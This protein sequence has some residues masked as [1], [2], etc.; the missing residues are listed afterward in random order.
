MIVE[1]AKLEAE[2]TVSVAYNDVFLTVDDLSTARTRLS[3]VVDTLAAI[4]ASVVGFD[5]SDDEILDTLFASLPRL[6][7]LISTDYSTKGAAE[8]KQ[9][10]PTFAALEDESQEFLVVALFLLENLPEE[11]DQS[12]VSISAW[13]AVE[14]ELN[15]KILLPFRDAFV[16]EHSEV[17]THL[18]SDLRARHGWE[19]K[20]LAKY[21]RDAKPPALGQ[22]LG[23]IAKCAHSKKTV[24]ESTALGA[25][26][27]YYVQTSDTEPFLF[28]KA[29]VLAILS[30][31]VI[32]KFRNGAAHTSV[33]NHQRARESFDYVLNALSKI[34]DGLKKV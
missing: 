16:R 25:L 29:G 22:T 20:E 26:K 11:S 30:Q 34:L 15:T 9:R 17:L 28:S 3:R 31:D 7:W 23:I 8:L 10:M 19:A 1:C 5:K 2:P 32:D 21:L 24:Q 33:L 27:A 6:S 14:N 4:K 12:T 13:K 18:E